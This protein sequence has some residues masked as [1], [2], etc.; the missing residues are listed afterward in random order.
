M[1]VVPPQGP[2]RLFASTSLAA[3][4]P[5]TGRFF[6]K[7]FFGFGCSFAFSVAYAERSV[8]D[9]VKGEN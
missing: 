1:L 3:V 7:K 6:G 8:T 9:G 5:I 4:G 2:C